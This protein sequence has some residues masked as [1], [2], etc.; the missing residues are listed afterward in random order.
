MFASIT[1][2]S[3]LQ[4][5]DW[6]EPSREKEIYVTVRATDNGRPQLDD[7]CTF[8][9]IVEDINDNPPTFDKVVSTCS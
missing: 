3:R 8:K 2:F 9:I 4:M 7:T 1:S 5:L 6:D